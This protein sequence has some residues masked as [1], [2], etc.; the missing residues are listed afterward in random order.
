MTDGPE[1]DA[2]VREVR[3]YAA[4]PI[5]WDLLPR[6]AG[7]IVRHEFRLALPSGRPQQSL[8]EHLAIIEAIARRDPAAAE[9]AAR[10]HL[11]SVI[12]ALQQ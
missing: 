7:Q 11:R 12:A 6:L 9:A 8:P 2:E 1:R 4:Q 10:A 3:E 5:A